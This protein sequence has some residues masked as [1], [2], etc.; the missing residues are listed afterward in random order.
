MRLELSKKSLI[1]LQQLMPGVY[2]APEIFVAS[3]RRTH[4]SYESKRE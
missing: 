1:P 2:Q 3:M 4:C